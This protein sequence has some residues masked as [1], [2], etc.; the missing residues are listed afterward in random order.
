[1]YV[2]RAKSESVSAA[3]LHSVSCARSSRSS[4]NGGGFPAI[5]FQTPGPTKPFRPPSRNT[6]WGYLLI[7][8]F[9]KMQGVLFV[10]FVKF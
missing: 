5:P 2:A 4:F 10:K 8:Y 9:R 7:S 6:Q 3:A 1:M